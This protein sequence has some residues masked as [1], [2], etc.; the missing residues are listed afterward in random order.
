VA[1]RGKTWQISAKSWQKVAEYRDFS[2]SIFE[3]L[4]KSGAACQAVKSRASNVQG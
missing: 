1:N 2:D 3:K 4:V